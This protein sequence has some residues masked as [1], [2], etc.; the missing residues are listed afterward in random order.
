V[1]GSRDAPTA[2]LDAD[3]LTS[4]GAVMGTVAYMSPEQARGEA[5][6]AR[7]DL[8]SFGAVLYEMATGCPAFDG[9]TSAVIS[10]KI[11]AEAPAPPLQRNPDLPPKLEEIISKALE[12]DV[13]LRYQHAS[14]IRTDLKR[15]KRDTD[16]GRSRSAAVS[17]AGAGASGSRTEEQHG[18]DAHATAGGTPALRREPTSDSVIIASPVKRHKESSIVAV[19]IVAALAGLALLLLRRPSQPP[20]AELAQTRLTFN[21]G[22]N[23][24]GSDAISPDG[25]YVA[26]SDP[27]GIHIEL[28][29]T[30]EERLIRKPSGVP[31]EA[32]W[33]P[34]SWFPDSTQLLADTWRPGAQRSIW[35]V[36]VV[37]QSPRELRDGA[38]AWAVSPDGT[39]I[40]FSP[41]AGPS[42]EV[43]EIWVMG[44]QGDNPKKVLALGENE[45]LYG[46]RWSP[47]GQR[48]AYVTWKRISDHRMSIETSDLIGTNRTVIVPDTDL[49]LDGFC[50]LPNGRIVYSRQES[51]GSDDDNLWQI[52]IDGH[53]G[54]PTDKP[55]RITQWVGSYLERL[56]ASAD[57]KRLTFRKA[58]YQGQVY[59]GELAPRGTRMNR[60]RRL[61][62]DEGND[63][64]S[65]WTP[66]SKAVLFSSERN[67]TGGIFKQGISQETAEPVLTGLPEFRL[68]LPRLSPD[69]A[70][71]LYAETPKTASP[72]T[73]DSLMRIPVSGGV[74]QLVL[75]MRNW[76]T[77]ACAR[78]PATLCGILEASQD[79]KHVMITAFDP[80]KGRGKVLRIIEKDPAAYM[81]GNLSPDGSTFAISRFNGEADI[82]IR[83][84]SLSGGSDRE[85]TVKGW[86]NGVGID[87]SP[88]GKGL[89]LGSVSVL[90]NRLTLAPSSRSTTI[91]HVDLKG[92]AR[93]LWQLKG[94]GG[95]GNPSPDGRYLLICGHATNS[96]VWMLEGF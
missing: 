92:N 55:Q 72:A 35:T 57:G 71:I 78:A 16:S 23:P 47:D 67:G 66:D 48:L 64:P 61:T 70:W 37:G 2:S 94:A 24:V 87:W 53:S 12:K 65:A 74:P 96:N 3:H 11:L 31:S 80:L 58:T 59:L 27:A 36:S 15:L 43:R 51:P 10:H 69:G 52:G 29:S 40:A 76:L 20:S 21:S 68:P 8:F 88:D 63:F 32:D 13:D 91:L 39:R 4:P 84:L 33:S 54:T 5:L 77:F 85:I 90:T 93:V 41:E 45:W 86:P 17:A 14:D 1:R 34:D 30:G 89:Y 73:P 44:S 19:A 42:G 7:T 26:Y 49:W 50:W 83:L 56:S 60:L 9:A 62:N 22:D 28:L 38:T 79:E 25:K 75:E 6:D 18:Q 82:H 81:N 46:V 95:C